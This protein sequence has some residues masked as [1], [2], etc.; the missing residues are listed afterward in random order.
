[1]ITHIPSTILLERLDV[2]SVTSTVQPPMS[3]L[4]PLSSTITSPAV[5]H[6]EMEPLSAPSQSPGAIG[7]A[8]NLY[9]VV[10]PKSFVLSNSNRPHDSA[11]FLTLFEDSA[12]ICRNPFVEQGA[13]LMTSLLIRLKDKI[14]ASVP[15]VWEPQIWMENTMFELQKVGAQYHSVS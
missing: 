12:A 10:Q 3:P 11:P 7:R 14:E 4:S 6:A 9:G 2:S 15:V 13:S 5:Q 8:D 1:M